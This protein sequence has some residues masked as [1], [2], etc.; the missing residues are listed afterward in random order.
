MSEEH[1]THIVE[2]KFNILIWIDLLIFTLITIEIAQFDFQ[3][4]TVVIALVVATIKTY[5]VGTY[6]MHLKFEN[7]FLQAIVIGVGILFFVVLFFLFTDYLY[8]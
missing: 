7:R 1:G 6:F 3:A 5:L 8:F 2:Y 4:L